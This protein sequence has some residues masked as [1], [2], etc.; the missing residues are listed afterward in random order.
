MVFLDWKGRLLVGCPVDS[1]QKIPEGSI[2]KFGRKFQVKNHSS[3][4]LNFN[5]KYSG[6]FAI[7]DIPGRGT[8]DNPHK[9]FRKYP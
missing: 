7:L 8:F 4:E 6:I 1:Q 2:R 5:P 9:I 3:I